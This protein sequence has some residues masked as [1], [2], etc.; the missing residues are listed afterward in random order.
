MATKG[1]Y[2]YG[3]IPNFYSAEMFR[4]LENS[5]IYTIAHQ[6]I[7]AIV[8]ERKNV[9]FDSLDRETLGHLLVD[10]QK[11]LEDMIGKGFNMLIPMRLGTMVNSKEE[12]FKILTNGH[13]LIV[14]TLNKI[15]HQTEIDLAVT[16]ADFPAIIKEV[17]SH[18][19][20][21]AMKENIMK[22][23]VAI[24]Q[25]DQIKI[26]MLMEEKFKEKNT[27]VELDIMNAL[28][29]FCTDI[30]M[31]DVMNDQM[32]TNS[33]YLI[34]WNNKEKFEQALDRLD[35][36]YKGMLNFKMVGPLPCY[37]FYTIEVKEL[38]PEHVSQAK[39]ELGLSETTSESE[40][41]K[42]YQEKAKEFHP[43]VN[44]GN[45]SI[46][47]FNRIKKAYQTLLEY[48]EAANFASKEHVI[49]LTKEN[50]IENL[51]LVKIKE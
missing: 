12:V 40:I 6:N 23:E 33:A 45:G 9:P 3:I 46:D 39:K 18:P 24:S 5:G 38:N 47:H 15:E 51:I 28:S 7:S 17:A 10:H 29:T 49:S 48:I 35:E 1:I 2:I 21:V 11:T 44:Q 22:K 42:A 43:D 26:G 34:N 16:W 41:K 30:K 31:H 20:I 14:D 25:I 36:E 32:I 8:S 4:S 37:S 19:D 13:D 27:T 50:L